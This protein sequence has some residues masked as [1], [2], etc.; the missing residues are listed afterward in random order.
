MLTFMYKVAV[1]LE[2]TIWI[3]SCMACTMFRMC[4][5]FIHCRTVLQH[6]VF[7]VLA[8][9]CVSGGHHKRYDCIQRYRWN[10]KT[11][12]LYGIGKTLLR[13]YTKLFRCKTVS[14]T[15]NLFRF[16]QYTIK[17]ALLFLQA[18]KWFQ[19]FVWIFIVCILVILFDVRSQPTND[20]PISIS[21]VYKNM[22]H[23]YFLNSNIFQSANFF[24]SKVGRKL[25]TVWKYD[26]IEFDTDSVH[27]DIDSL[28]AW[29]TGDRTVWEFW[30]D[31]W[32]MQMEWIAH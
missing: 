23:N 2:N 1:R 19:R 32:P 24:A 18:Y 29:R 5:H 9:H 27:S 12:R 21:W 8:F 6:C 7:V 20:T 31:A 14:I 15:V 26:S 11:Q 22:Q 4:S 10:T 25:N 17:F 13:H 3:C 30:C 16:A 28:W